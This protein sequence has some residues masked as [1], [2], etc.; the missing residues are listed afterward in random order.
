MDS[1]TKEE[2]AFITKAYNFAKKAHGDQKRYSGEPFFS[3]PFETAKHLAKI[4]MG[5]NMVSAGLLHDT[6]EDLGIAPEV[7]EEEFNKDVRTLVEGV[8]K[9]GTVRYHGMKRHTESL[10][11]LFAATSQDVR[12]MIIKLLDRLHNARTLEH[13]PDEEKRC[14]IA[15]E[16]LEIYAPIADR[17]GMGVIKREL[18][19]AV[20][21]F[22]HPEDYKEIKKTFKEAGGE[23]IKKLDKIHKSIK[24]KLAEYGIK[25]FSTSTRVKGLYSFFKKLGRKGGDVDQ[26]RDVWALRII[27]PTIADCYT[28][29]G[30]IHAEWK[31]M[32]GRIKDYIA[33]P[34]P[35][36]YKSIHTTIHTGDGGVLE[37]QIRTENMHKEAQYGIASHITYK[38]SD[39][40]SKGMAGTGMEWI[41]QFIP[42]R[43]LFT[44]SSDGLARPVTY[45]GE[46]TPEWIKHMA[47]TSRKT[48]P[49]KY[50]E[51]IKSDFFSHR[52][53][54]FTPKGDVID[55]PI[56]STP[57][58]FA[59]A[60]HSNI[61]HHISGAKVNNKMTSLD[62][63]L[64][65]GDIVE[66][67]TST[68][69]RP[70]RKWLG[71]A[72]TNMAKRFIRT[73][74]ARQKNKNRKN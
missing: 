62:T 6:V 29:M 5:P 39:G 59:Y 74:I 41:K 26:I 9:L 69:A 71:Y 1:P 67:L 19:D 20:F 64:H 22:A 56:D 49:N 48:K 54:A 38:E 12:V 61:G 10:R 35:N 51:E 3:H 72:K 30:V 31:P 65:N 73:Y 8:T 68:Q 34:K 27:V 45:S 50:M 44:N 57:I 58:D 52:I 37:V 32:P 63:V 14:R 24:K 15:L 60:I 11:K 66:I 55:L 18:E 16:T 46:V 7:I 23:D 70:T 47:D 17:L 40:K 28:V 36:G 53:F 43:L 21:P 25:E 42:T 13:V 33:F 4:G 2:V